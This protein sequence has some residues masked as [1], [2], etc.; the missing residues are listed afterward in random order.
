MT[1]V[2]MS[3]R[4]FSRLDVLLRV[5]CGRLRIDDGCALIGLKRRQVFRL[6]AGLKQDGAA[7]L[8][9]KRRGKPGNHRHPAEVRALALSIVRE[10]YADFGPTF[11]A[12]KLAD[13]HG[14]AVSRETLRGWMIADGLWVDR[15]HRLASPHQ[16]RRR[17]EC[18]GELVQID[19]SEHA[20]FEARGETCTLLAFIDDATSRLMQRRFVASESS[21]DYFRTMRAYLE[22]HGKPVAFYSDKHNIFRVNAKDAVSGDAITQ[23]GR[24]L[25]ELNIDIICANTLLRVL[26]RPQ[27]KGRVERA[28][29]T[30]QDRLV[31]E[32]RLAG[33]STIAAA[34]AWLPGFI[35]GHNARFAK[36]PLN[37]K[38]LHRPLTQADNLDEVIAW[39][40]VRTVTGNLTLHYDRMLLLLEPTV[41][42]RGLARKKV[43]VVNYPD[44]RFAVQFEGASVPFRVFDKIQT[45]TQGAIV[46]NKRL[47]AALALVKE[48]QA[49]YAPHKR[50][51]DPAR[52]RPPNNLE[53]P[54][55]PTKS[56]PRR[57]AVPVAS[58]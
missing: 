56:R 30:L 44:G 26:S 2:S 43:D 21:F 7:S 36:P 50:R 1:V 54:G 35:A 13:H 55:M 4:E 53:A 14:Y 39:R 49:T 28:F 48:H 25:S 33:I 11:A 47:G 46:E 20:W 41:F 17:R 37:A 23:F 34:N 40:E 10:R 12:E 57:G 19:G 42:A 18:L 24:V 58:V 6:L 45:V 31:K 5:Q 8:A 32:L 22:E 51:Y 27:A 16:P 38:N 52:Q 15:R 9:S 3:K 29:A